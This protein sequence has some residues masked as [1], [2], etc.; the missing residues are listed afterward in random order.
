M[1]HNGYALAMAGQFITFCPNVCPVNEQKVDIFILLLNR[2]ISDRNPSPIAN[3]KL[4]K[5]TSALLLPMRCC[6]PALYLYVTLRL[7]INFENLLCNRKNSN[8]VTNIKIKPIHEKYKSPI[9]VKV[10]SPVETK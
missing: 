6:T 1:T 10:K 2:V 5:C 4:M 7:F 3:K 8:P 9:E